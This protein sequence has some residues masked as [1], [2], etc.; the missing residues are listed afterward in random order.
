MKKRALLCGI[1]AISM[2]MSACAKK[3]ETSSTANKAATMPAS[4]AKQEM[5]MQ[6]ADMANNVASKANGDT[7][8]AGS[9]SDEKQKVDTKKIIKNATLYIYED[10]L[11][12]LSEAI[13]K[14]VDELGGYVEN[15]NVMEE[16]LTT[17]VRIPAEKFDEFIS[18]TEKGFTVKNKT[19][20]SEN[21]TDAYVD[22]EARLKNLK[23][24]EEQVLAILKK[25]NTVEEVL[26]VQAELYKIRGEAE[27]LE[28]RK[29][30]WDKQ[31]DYA[32]ITINADKKIIV[33]ESKDKIIGGSDFFK[34][35]GKG[36]TNTSVA[37]I[38]A[39]QHILIFVFSNIIV[40]AFLAL[41]GF[42]GFKYYKK[43]NNR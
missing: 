21:I 12:N 37:L 26:K 22:N 6:A 36:F 24:Q 40:F 23:A 7:K 33:A 8:T 30:S 9:Q 11:V 17:R 3:S 5:G 28:A 41:A 39:V 29:K 4:E 15:D 13:R 31:V 25:A 2:L 14:K 32:T 42:F 20:S 1:L 34:S 10:N 38:L 35:I 43:Y 19:V 16:R 27:A 18:Y